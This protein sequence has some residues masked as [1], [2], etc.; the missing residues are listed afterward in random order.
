MKAKDAIEVLTDDLSL[1]QVVAALEGIVRQR[2]EN[3]RQS[4]TV[5]G[6]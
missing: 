1:V 2:I 4:S 3:K 6:Q 5:N